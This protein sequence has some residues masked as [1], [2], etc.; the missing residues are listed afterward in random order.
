MNTLIQQDVG[1]KILQVFTSGD[2]QRLFGTDKELARADVTPSNRSV[3]IQI[4][5]NGIWPSPT[6]A[7]FN[8]RHFGTWVS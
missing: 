2:S 6:Y 4:Q 7:R 1:G 8:G 5:Q 3:L